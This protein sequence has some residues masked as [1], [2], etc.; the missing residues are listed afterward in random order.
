M[1]AVV[2]RVTGASVSINGVQM[3][4]I[5][6]GLLV[7]IGTCDEDGA[8]DIEWLAGRVANL[9]LFADE[10]AAWN[11]SIADIEGELLIVSQFTLFASTKKGSRPSWHRAAKPGIAEPLYRAFITRLEELLPGRV[12]TGCFGAMMHV[13]LENDGPVTLW[14]D[15]R[16]RE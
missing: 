4:R 7:L 12:R 3:A 16:A 11:R 8:E 1:R 5:G 14:L 2:Q 10:A 6:P 13:A 9:R 15:S